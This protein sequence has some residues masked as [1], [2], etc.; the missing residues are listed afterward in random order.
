MFYTPFLVCVLVSGVW[1]ASANFW[2]A[3]GDYESELS[4]NI[5]E[6]VRQKAIFDNFYV[7]MIL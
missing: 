2:L 1:A 4:G 3:G 6:K 7:V 5:N